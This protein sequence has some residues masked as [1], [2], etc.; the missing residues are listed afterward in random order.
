MPLRAQTLLLTLAL[1]TCALAQDPLKT[2]PDNYTRVLDNPTVEVIRAH[3]GP[4]EKIPVHDHSSLSTVFVYLS[5]SGQVRI[6]HAEPGEKPV[7]ILR[8]PTTTGAFRVNEGAA[9]RHS[10]ENL[11]DTPSDFLRIE[12]K[13]VTLHLPEAFRGKAPKSLATSSDTVEFTN[14]SV[15]VERIICAGPTAC[16]VASSPF[17]SLLVAFTAA[18]LVNPTE[19]PNRLASGSLLW[20]PAS[21][22]ATLIPNGSPAHILRILFPSPTP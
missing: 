12:L 22:S 16:P 6:D 19:Q 11:G 3:Y 8:P 1:T 4:N 21:Q 9:E 5:D 18:S 2:L 10:I 20:F 14:P 15:Q 17:P 13:N 7:S